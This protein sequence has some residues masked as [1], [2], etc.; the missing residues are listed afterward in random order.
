[1]QTWPSATIC[2]MTWNN[3]SSFSSGVIMADCSAFCNNDVAVSS[4]FNWAVRTTA[5]LKI[6][7][8]GRL[9]SYEQTHVFTQLH[10][11]HLPNNAFHYPIFKLVFSQLVREN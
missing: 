2:L 10:T 8:A 1:M 11:I 6:A 4:W 3:I 9:K 7:A 5:L